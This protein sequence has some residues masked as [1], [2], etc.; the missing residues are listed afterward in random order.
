MTAQA[1]HMTKEDSLVN[2]A[3]SH[4][5]TLLTKYNLDQDVNNKN[6]TLYMRLCLNYATLCD[7][8]D[9]LMM[10]KVAQKAEALAKVLSISP[11]ELLDRLLA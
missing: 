1:K 9:I 2:K 7:H 8:A 10:E 5:I 6:A 3:V 11:Q 4:L